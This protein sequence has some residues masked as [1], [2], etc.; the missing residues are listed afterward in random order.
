MFF[1][2]LSPSKDTF[3]SSGFRIWSW[4]KLWNSWSVCTGRVNYQLSEN[5]YFFH[6]SYCFLL[7]HD[8]LSHFLLSHFNTFA[9]AVI[10]SQPYFKH[11]PINCYHI[12]PFACLLWYDFLSHWPFPLFHTCSHTQPKS[13]RWISIRLSFPLPSFSLQHLRFYS[14]SLATLLHLPITVATSIFLPV[15]LHTA[16][17]LSHLSLSSIPVLLQPK[18]CRWLNTFDLML[19]RH[20]IRSFFLSRSFLLFLFPLSHAR[21]PPAISLKTFNAN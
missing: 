14:H 21:S 13:C 10:P 9:P 3:V 12:T 19:K 11:L 18:S 2:L 5:N 8:F 20:S 16:F 15:L 6:T 1:A 17:F 4:H 7:L